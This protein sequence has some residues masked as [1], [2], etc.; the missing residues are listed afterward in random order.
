MTID[1]VKK[2]KDAL[3]EKLKVSFGST[4]EEA[5]DAQMITPVFQG[6]QHQFIRPRLRRDGVAVADQRPV[7]LVCQHINVTEEID[8]VGLF[9]GIHSQDSLF[10]LVAHGKISAG[11]RSG[12]H[13]AG[14]HFCKSGKVQADGNCLAPFHRKT[15]RIALHPFSSRDRH[16]CLS[17]KGQRNDGFRINSVCSVRNGS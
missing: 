11:Q 7:S 9:R 16:A 13:N 14:T 2:M 5:S 4:V 3:C 15:H 8:R 6:A 10:R 17:G 12:N 1:S